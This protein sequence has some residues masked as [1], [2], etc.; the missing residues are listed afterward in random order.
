[1]E[2]LQIPVLRIRKL[3]DARHVFTHLEWQM[4]GYELTVENMD[5]LPMPDTVLLTK[6]ELQS[7]AV[8]SAFDVY[9]KYYD[10]RSESS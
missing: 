7:F 4:S 8:P 10:L 5:A 9:M 1:M 6:K 3:P 2:S